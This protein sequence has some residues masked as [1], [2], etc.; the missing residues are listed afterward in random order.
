MT[1][2]V[3]LVCL[4]SSGLERRSKKKSVRKYGGENERG[5]GDLNVPLSRPDSHC[6]WDIT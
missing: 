4:P 3:S 6:S 1:L 5:R 2:S